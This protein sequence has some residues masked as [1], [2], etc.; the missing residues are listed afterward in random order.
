MRK[1]GESVYSRYLDLN[2]IKNEFPEDGYKG[3]YIKDIALKIKKKI[4]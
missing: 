3:D 4:S 2:N 1:L